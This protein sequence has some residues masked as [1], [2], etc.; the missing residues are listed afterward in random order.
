MGRTV[1]GPGGIGGPGGSGIG[2]FGA[3]L[4]QGKGSI[5]AVDSVPTRSSTGDPDRFF[6]G[7]TP[8]DNQLAGRRGGEYVADIVNFALK[9][10]R[11]TENLTVSTIHDSSETAGTVEWDAD[12]RLLSIYVGATGTSRENGFGGG[13]LIDAVAATDAPVVVTNTSRSAL[14]LIYPDQNIQWDGGVDADTTPPD[15]TRGLFVYT[16]ET[17][18]EW[19]LKAVERT[20]EEEAVRAGATY[21]A[22]EGNS[23]RLVV[24]DTTRNDRLWITAD[25]PPRGYPETVNTWRLI[26]DEVGE[27]RSRAIA[28]N[29]VLFRAKAAGSAPDGITVEARSGTPGVPAIAGSPA[30]LQV[31]GRR[32]GASADA[33]DVSFPIGTAGNGWTVDPRAAVSVAAAAASARYKL[34]DPDGTQFDRFLDLEY[35]SDGPAGNGF[36]VV[37]VDNIDANTNTSTAVYDSD[38]QMTVTV[39]AGPLLQTPDSL[40]AVINAARRNGNQLIRAS[41]PA[42]TSNLGWAVT[43]GFFQAGTA[44]L[45]GGV[46]AGS[47]ANGFATVDTANKVLEIALTGNVRATAFTGFI[48]AATG[49]PGTA[50][51]RSGQGNRNIQPGDD[52]SEASSGG[53]D[54]VP[55]VPRSA[56]TVTE[57]SNG[58]VVTITGLLGTD[59]IAQLRAAASALTLIDVVTP[60]DRTDSDTVVFPLAGNPGDRQFLVTLANGSAR[61]TP[62][63]SSDSRGGIFEITIEYIG[64][65]YAESLRTTLAEFKALWEVF[66]SRTDNIAFTET[67]TQSERVTAVPSG[68]DGG[69]NY[70]PPSP[71]EFIVHDEDAA[72]ARTV[73]VR[74]HADFDTLSNIYLNSQIDSFNPDGVKIFPIG[75]SNLN[76]RPPDP[77][78]EKPMVPS[79]ASAELADE[80]HQFAWAG[81]TNSISHTD[82]EYL[83]HDY[84]IFEGWIANDANNREFFTTTVKRSLIPATIAGT[85]RAEIGTYA[86]AAGDRAGTARLALSAE[87][88]L[89]LD[90]GASRSNNGEIRVW[91]STSPS[92]IGRGPQGTPGRNVNT[93]GGLSTVQTDDTLTG[94]GSSGDPLKVAN[95]FTA[96]DE[97]K[98]D[99]IEAGAEVNVQ[100]DWDATAGD[101]FINNKPTIPTVPDKASNSDVD[102]ETDDTDYTTVAKVF[103]AIG[104]KVRDASKTARGIIEI[105]ANSELDTGTDDERAVTPLGVNRM[106]ERLVPSWARQANAP[107]SGDT[108][109]TKLFTDAVILSGDR[110]LTSADVNKLFYSELAGNVAITLPDASNSSDEDILGFVSDGTGS[111]TV[112]SLTVASGQ[113]LALIYISGSGWVIFADAGRG[114]GDDNVQPDWDQTDDTADDYIENKPDIPEVIDGLNLTLAGTTLTLTAEQ[115][116]TASDIVATLDVSSLEEYRGEWNTLSGQTIRVGDIISHSNRYFISR[117]EHTRQNNGPDTDSTRFALLTNWGGAYDEDGYYHSGT[118]V[119]YNS[120]LWANDSDVLNSDPDPDATANTKWHRLS[121]L[122]ATEIL[123]AVPAASTTTAGLIEIATN[124][125]GDTGT[126]GGRAMTPAGVRRQTGAQ[127]SAAERAATTPETSVRRFSPADIVAMI[128]NHA[129]TGGLSTSEVLALFSTWARV[130]DTSRIPANRLDTDV[131][132][133]AELTTAIANFRTETQINALIT[134]ALD[135]LDALTNA[136]VYANGT[137][138]EAGAVVRHGGNGTQATYLC[139]QDIGANIAASEPGVGADWRTSWY[140]IGFEDGPPNAFTGATRSGNSII[141]SRES[142]QNPVTVSAQVEAGELVHRVVGSANYDFS[143]TN[144][145]TYVAENINETPIS[146]G[147]IVDGDLLGITIGA[148]TNSPNTLVLFPASVIA[149]SAAV[150][151]TS[152]AANRVHIENTSFTEIPIGL[153]WDSD[154]HL[155]AAGNLTESPSPLTLYRFSKNADTGVGNVISSQLGRI[156]LAADHVEGTWLGTGAS[157]PDPF[158]DTDVFHFF[159]D[160]ASSNAYSKFFNGAELDFLFSQDYVAGAAVPSDNTGQ[161][162]FTLGGV[163]FHIGRSASGEILLRSVSD[164]IYEDSVFELD[165][166]RAPRGP[167]GQGWGPPTELGTTT[168]DLDGSAT[169][170]PLVG[171][172][173]NALVC[174]QGGDINAVISIPTLGLV[175][176]SVWVLA[177]DLREAVA[178]AALTASLYTNDDNEIIFRAGAQSGA[179]TANEI[180]IRHI[181]GADEQ[182]DS[183]QSI[184]PSIARFDLTGDLSPNVGSIAGDR[185]GYDLAISQSGHAGSARIVGFAGTSANPSAVTVL[186]EVTDLHSESGTITIP[187]GITLAS[188]GDVYTVRLEVYT[189]SQTPATDQPRIYHDARIVAHAVAAT[190]HF[191]YIL[192]DEDATDVDFSTDDITSRGAV[193]GDWTV[194]GLPQGDDEYRIYWAV[195]TSLTQPGNW[196]TSGFNVNSSIDPAVERTIDGTAYNFYLSVADSPFDSTG[197]GITYTVS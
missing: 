118:I 143:S 50:Q 157:L 167:I 53:I 25:S 108:T 95:P 76:S 83:E 136:G 165:I 120:L 156:Q 42:G 49:F 123:A 184:L 126:D 162:A 121:P 103:R 159:F 181:P 191:G 176:S 29:G 52:A 111:I 40:A 21:E 112:G 59:T 18:P 195:P 34:F 89:T 141:F 60:S 15:P 69:S 27:W 62:S 23:L 1:V 79:G 6:G 17:T 147:D 67:G 131:V 66:E 128:G 158:V 12:D 130:A 36:Q 63:I 174:P 160:D 22:G 139:I 177:D 13:T 88:E 171:T 127:V 7:G 129:A 48:N 16:D 46:N 77:P 61:P 86:E 148:V 65:T 2:A 43:T 4:E 84:L 47:E 54:A 3:I 133:S 186:A 134:T 64:S 19:Q 132:L 90:P 80:I 119:L 155:L 38:T 33:I 85:P 87:G 188:A 8:A 125:E 98:L 58:R 45:S 138:Y 72:D 73:E 26:H 149:D 187:A 168:F 101:A 197:N 94:D 32:S 137:A 163:D 107:S 105:A 71:I 11:S 28:G 150:G 135:G 170:V 96:A 75:G 20:A 93:G 183:G 30:I 68:F 110:T 97:T 100:P 5:V 82:L 185:Y 51:T 117:T 152:D 55:A 78:F 113:S 24:G 74:Y 106:V 9:D 169:N 182:T 194:T 172:D 189:P 57:A 164:D 180:L 104:R 122:T 151:D 70:I 142:G 31:Q 196:V 44:T 175:G 35:T 146:R 144:Q 81:S 91:G 115:T 116:G 193:A 56:L 124:T 39:G 178:N 173:G 145:N 114:G 92:G 179:S 161:I 41:R 154:G 166:L 102:G 153:A 10:G 109:V 190:V 99:G 140:R 192:S 37:F 14:Y